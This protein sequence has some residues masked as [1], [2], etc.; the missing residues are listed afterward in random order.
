MDQQAEGVAAVLMAAGAGRRL[1]HVPKSLLLRAGEPLLLRQI[2]LLAQAGAAHIVV[3]LG[4]HAQALQ[5]VLAQARVPPGVSLRWAVNAAPDEGPGS[6]LRCGLAALPPEAGTLLVLLAD[7]PLL[8]L[9]DVQAM[10]AAWQ[11]RAAGVELVVPQHAGQPGH[12]I[13]FGAAL[14]QAVM[15]AAGGQGVRE[16]RR[17]HPAQVQAVALQHER[18]T[19]DVDTPEDLQ[20]LG[21]RFGVW[22]EQPRV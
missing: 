18:C 12:P 14:R 22:L 4:H 10:L 13:V 9:A 21:E 1:G 5:A 20:R 6:S 7:Q 2:R 8:E 15:Q 19:T 16:W 11:A 3:V 17:A